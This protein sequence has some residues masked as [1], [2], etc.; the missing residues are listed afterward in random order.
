[1]REM[2]FCIQ[3][4]FI[5]LAVT[6]FGGALRARLTS[7]KLYFSPA[8]FFRDLILKSLLCLKP[9]NKVLHF[10]GAS[11]RRVQYTTA[12]GSLRGDRA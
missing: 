8:L 9:Q 7:R 12:H 11:P 5:V 2:P 10:L 1:M 6:N 4:V 3:V